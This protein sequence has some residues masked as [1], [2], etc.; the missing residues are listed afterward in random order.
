MCCWNR[1][2]RTPLTY[3]ENNSEH[4]S[5]KHS[6]IKVTQSRLGG[7]PP[8]LTYSSALQPVPSGEFRNRNI[9]MYVQ[10]NI[11]A[12]QRNH[13]CCGKAISITYSEC[14]SVVLVIQ[15]AKRMGRIMSSVVCPALHYFSTV[16]QKRYDFREKV[17]LNIQ[18]VFSYSL[19]LPSEK[20]LILRRIQRDANI[21]V[22]RSQVTYQLF[23]SD[24]NEAW[25]F[26]TDFRKRYRI[27]WKSVQWE[28]SCSVRTGGQARRS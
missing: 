15:H 4:S 23:L 20:F 8:L 3:L 21:N 28:S 27:S 13:R 7:T 22:Y 10:R 17:L 24:F 1:L 5:I 14:V 11:E 19:Q 18:C 26:S 25:I 16:S 9:Q 2:I 12:S 6:E